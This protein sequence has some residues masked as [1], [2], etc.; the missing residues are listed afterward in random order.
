MTKGNFYCI[1][2]T[3]YEEYQRPFVMSSD[4]VALYEFGVYKQSL[5]EKCKDDKEAL[6]VDKRYKLMKYE[7]ILYNVAD[8]FFLS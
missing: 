5:K 3:L 8:G 4:Q 6:Q 1:Y 2:D 7:D